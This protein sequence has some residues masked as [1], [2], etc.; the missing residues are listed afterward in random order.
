MQTLLRSHRAGDRLS[1]SCGRLL[2]ADTIKSQANR[3]MEERLRQE[4]P[5]YFRGF[6][7][8]AHTELWQ[9]GC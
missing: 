8:Y 4:S 6:T 7:R 9:Y 3:A 2:I 5:K 1:G